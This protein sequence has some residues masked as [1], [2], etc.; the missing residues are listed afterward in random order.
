MDDKP[1]VLTSDDLAAFERSTARALAI[2]LGLLAEATGSQKLAYHLGAALSAAEQQQPDA[3]R[4]RLLDQ[5]F[6]MVL[7]KALHHA[8]DD[9]VLQDLAATLR[10]RQTKH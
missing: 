10:A 5:A 9:P 3:T 7:T 6:R 2:A 8:P 4:D 1:R